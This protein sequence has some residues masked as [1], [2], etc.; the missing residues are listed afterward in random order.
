MNVEIE[1][2]GS[3]ELPTRRVTIPLVEEASFDIDKLPRVIGRGDPDDALAGSTVDLVGD[4]VGEELSFRYLETLPFATDVWTVQGTHREGDQVRLELGNVSVQDKHLHLRTSHAEAEGVQD[5]DRLIGVQ[6]LLYRER[7]IFGADFTVGFLP[8]VEQEPIEIPVKLPLLRL[9]CPKHDGCASSLEYAEARGG[10]VDASILF[11]GIEA[12]QGYFMK[13]KVSRTWRV[14][15]QTC[16]QVA[17]P[18]WLRLEFGTTCANDLPVSYGLRATVIAVSDD[19]VEHTPIPD[20]LDTCQRPTTEIPDKLR[21]GESLRIGHGLQSQTVAY[22]AEKHVS[23]RIGVDLE[24]GAV[25][26]KLAVGFTRSTE[27]KSVLTTTLAPGAQYLN[28][29]PFGPISAGQV[30][31]VCWTSLPVEASAGQQV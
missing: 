31:E 28:Y 13:A 25:P 23:G 29:T 4:V 10:K 14:G 24:I 2:V 7:R 30:A 6:E 9:H 16:L 1:S 19:P 5:G 22:E 3:I 8:N 21:L 11:F 27:S 26:V 17:V 18:G 15:D 12:K 20:N